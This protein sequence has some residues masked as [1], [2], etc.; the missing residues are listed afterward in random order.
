[1]HRKIKIAIFFFLEMHSL[2]KPEIMWQ[3]SRQKSKVV[4]APR[5]AALWLQC[6]TTI[7]T[8]LEFQKANSKGKVPYG[9][10]ARVV[11]EYK[12]SFPWL[13]K[14]MVQNPKPY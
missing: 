3:S 1:L 4:K 8:E 13:S 14:D 10:L 12:E 2:K 9:A 11:Q 7:A 5:I 6:L